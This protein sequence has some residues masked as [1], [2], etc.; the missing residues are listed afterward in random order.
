MTKRE[1]WSPSSNVEAAA[2]PHHQL[3]VLWTPAGGPTTS[4][5]TVYWHGIRFLR[6][7]LSPTVP[8]PTSEANGKPRLLPVLLRDQLQTRGSMVPPVQDASHQVQTVTCASDQLAIKQRFSWPLIFDY[9]N[10]FT[11]LVTIKREN[12]SRCGDRQGEVLNKGASALV[13]SAAST[14]HWKHSGSPT[15]KFSWPSR[16]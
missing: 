16:L 2:S 3:P 10:P 7:G 14:G 9:S 13:E 15:W 12:N 11:H 4:P 1:L 6:K 5:D 8:A